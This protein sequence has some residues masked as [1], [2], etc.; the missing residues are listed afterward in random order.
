MGY[1]EYQAYANSS[2]IKKAG[3]AS[4]NIQANWRFPMSIRLDSFDG[5]R[6]VYED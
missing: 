6:V 1:G 4:N 3:F 2:G 5:H